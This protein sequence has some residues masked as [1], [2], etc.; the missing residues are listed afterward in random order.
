MTTSA[1]LRRPGRI[2]IGGWRCWRRQTVADAGE[3][4]ESASN[5]LAR[6]SPKPEAGTNQ[7]EV[8]FDAWKLAEQALID[9]GAVH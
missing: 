7:I 5:V 4:F 6:P 8:P 9:A 1:D 3:T 2:R